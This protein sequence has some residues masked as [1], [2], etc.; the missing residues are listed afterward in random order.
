MEAMWDKLSL[1]RVYTKP[2][3]KQP[4]YSEP[5]VLRASKSTVEDFVS[6]RLGARQGERVRTETSILS[7]SATP[8]IG[9]LWSN[10][11]QPLSTANLSSIS[12]RGWDWPTSCATRMLVSLFPLSFPELAS[13]GTVGHGESIIV[14]RGID[15]RR[16]WRPSER[17]AAIDVG[18]PCVSL[19]GSSLLR[20]ACQP[21][22]QPRTPHLPDFVMK[23]KALTLTVCSNYCP[24]IRSPDVAEAV[25]LSR[26]VRKKVFHLG[27]RRRRIH[28]R[29]TGWCN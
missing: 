2:K 22:L 14:E 16:F 13:G 1:K 24:A 18:W 8:F 15:T 3:G 25:L 27:G 28:V 11:R 29:D 4:D 7:C 9:L 21:A 26:S 19:H 20:L 6:F 10:S 17:P 12:R 23:K 5:V